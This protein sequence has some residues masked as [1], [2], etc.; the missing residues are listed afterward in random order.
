M[1]EVIRIVIRAFKSRVSGDQGMCNP[2]KAG[3]AIAT[4]FLANVIA[5]M[6]GCIAC[7]DAGGTYTV[8]GTVIDNATDD[9]PEILGLEIRLLD[10]DSRING[11]AVYDTRISES[12]AFEASGDFLTA[13]ACEPL[14]LAALIGLLTGPREPDPPIPDR[15]EVLVRRGDGGCTHI[16]AADVSEDAV[17]TSGYDVEIELTDP[18]VVGN[19]PN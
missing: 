19:C 18:I 13:G 4:F 10:D 6:T 1:T 15:V 9:S 16:V 8:R 17:V 3:T 5:Q 12:G 7:W 11:E 2:A 14:V